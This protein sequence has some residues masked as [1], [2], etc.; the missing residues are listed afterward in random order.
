VAVSGDVDDL[1]LAYCERCPQDNAFWVATSSALTASVHDHVA[2]VHSRATGPRGEDGL[3]VWVYGQ[4]W[5][6]VNEGDV[7]ALNWATEVPPL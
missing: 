6:L 5:Y 2:E 1:L 7:E 4:D 3:P